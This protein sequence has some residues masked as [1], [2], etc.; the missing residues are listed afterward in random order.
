MFCYSGKRD[1]KLKNKFEKIGC[2]VKNIGILIKCGIEEMD[3]CQAHNLKTQIRVLLPQP[4]TAVA[5]VESPIVGR[6]WRV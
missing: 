1:R 6:G 2:M 5:Q 4:V 3:P